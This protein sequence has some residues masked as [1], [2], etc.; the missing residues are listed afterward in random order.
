MS[1]ALIPCTRSLMVRLLFFDELEPEEAARAERQQV[2][3]LADAREARV[4][5][6]LDGIAPLEGAQIELDRLS[7]ASHVVH[8]KDLIVLEGAQVGE[9]ARVRRL[10]PLIASEAEHGVLLAQRDEAMQP[11]QETRR[12][13]ELGLHVH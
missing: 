1:S 4:P 10:D 9:D 13:S 11:A 5:E 8:A 7:R 6:Q 12:G 3:E 2:G